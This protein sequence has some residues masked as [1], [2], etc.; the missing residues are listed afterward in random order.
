V[1]PVACIDSMCSPV[2]EGTLG[3]HE[4][5]LVVESGPGFGDGRGVVQ[6]ADGALD[7]GQVAAGDDRRGLV[8]DADLWAVVAISGAHFPPSRLG[9]RND[10]NRK[11]NKKSTVYHG[12][13]ISPLHS[14][15]RKWRLL[16]FTLL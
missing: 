14:K 9:S 10:K 8:V 15:R 12:L 5:E 3:V 2:D 4:V 7:L 16:V 6:H 13:T 1:K 11:N